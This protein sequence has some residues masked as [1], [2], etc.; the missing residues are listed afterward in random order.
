MPR[1]CGGR[2]WFHR[3]KPTWQSLFP[4]RPRAPADYFFSFIY[5]NRNIAESLSTA[6]HKTLPRQDYLHASP[7]G[8]FNFSPTAI[9]FHIYLP[10][11]TTLP[12]LS[13]YRIIPMP[14]SFLPLDIK[15]YT[16][17]ICIFVLGLRR[18]SFLLNI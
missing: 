17:F 13:P 9:R 11:T 8:I 18:D 16:L 4:D 10:C 1:G 12:Q 2:G 7:Q 15:I 5:E 3:V 14:F 6:A